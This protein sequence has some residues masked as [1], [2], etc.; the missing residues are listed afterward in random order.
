[1][2]AVSAVI[3]DE[4][5]IIVD[6]NSPGAELS[7]LKKRIEKRLSLDRVDQSSGR[8]LERPSPNY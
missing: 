2:L 6:I 7:E 1:M 4:N 8:L 3:A 5:G